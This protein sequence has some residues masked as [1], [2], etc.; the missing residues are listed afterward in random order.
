[1]TGS[2]NKQSRVGRP[3]YLALSTDPSGSASF[4]RTLKSCSPGLSLLA[5]YDTLVYRFSH[6]EKSKHTKENFQLMD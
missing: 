4:L 3:A 2:R 1:M 5:G 6:G